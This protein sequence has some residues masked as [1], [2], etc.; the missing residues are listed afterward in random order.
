MT[1]VDVLA[2]I[3]FSLCIYNI[4][5][6]TEKKERSLTS[7]P[8]RVMSKHGSNFTSSNGIT[9]VGKSISG[10]N[11]RV[12]SVECFS[13]AAATGFLYNVVKE[14]LCHNATDRSTAVWGS[15]IASTRT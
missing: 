8:L 12:V 1:T 9:K 4:L 5:T 6:K 2:K 15:N 7:S 14:L 3:L 11:E 10:V 13:G